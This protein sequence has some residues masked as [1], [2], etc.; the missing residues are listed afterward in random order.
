MAD[1]TARKREQ[2]RREG[3]EERHCVPSGVHPP[4]EQPGSELA[5]AGLSVEEAG[6]QDA[7]HAGPRIMAGTA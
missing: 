3:G 5:Q 4:P 2:L 7:R 1:S 6:Q